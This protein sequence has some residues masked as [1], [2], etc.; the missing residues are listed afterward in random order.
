MFVNDKCLPKECCDTTSQNGQF[1]PECA[2]LN[3]MALCM[4][5]ATANG[6]N[7]RGTCHN[8][9]FECPAK[10]FCDGSNDFGQGNCVQC[11]FCGATLN[12]C[13]HC[14]DK[15]DTDE[16]HFCTKEGFR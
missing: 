3:I 6:G 16:N 9:D 13:P 12:S 4:S 10:Q 14:H 7:R 11:T 15:C 1:N 2:D 5:Q 8:N